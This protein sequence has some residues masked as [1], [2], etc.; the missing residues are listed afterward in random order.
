MWGVGIV[1]YL[2]LTKLLRFI[3]FDRLAFCCIIHIRSVEERGLSSVSCE[4]TFWTSQCFLC[5]F[6]ISRNTVEF[7]Q[8]VSYFQGL[9]SATHKWMLVVLARSSIELITC[10]SILSY[11][12]M[13]SPLN[14]VKGLSSFFRN[15]YVG[16]LLILSIPANFVSHPS[17]FVLRYPSYR[18]IVA[19]VG[20]R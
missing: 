15:I 5:D 13:P 14:L 18:C 19:S 11:R 12:C 10:Y 3:L 9:F 2:L 4:A 20:I 1:A 8:P 16:R 6:V 7:I 17:F